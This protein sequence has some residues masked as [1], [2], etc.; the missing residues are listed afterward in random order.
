[1]LE[2]KGMNRSYLHWGGWLM[3][4]LTA[5]ETATVY[6]SHTKLVNVPK[7]M[8]FVS[9]VKHRALVPYYIQIAIIKGTICLRLTF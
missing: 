8:E 5:T 1:M 4:P 2:I 3:K 9:V 6:L 7:S